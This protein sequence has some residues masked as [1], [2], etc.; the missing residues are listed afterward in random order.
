VDLERHPLLSEAAIEPSRV[1]FVGSM[2]WRANQ[3]AIDWF[4][5]E[6][7]PRLSKLI[8]YRLWV[9]GR[10]PPPWLLDRTR[11]P[12]QIEV[13]GEVEDVKPFFERSAAVVVPLRVGGGSR[14]KILEAFASAA[15][16]STIGAEGLNVTAGKE[17]FS[18]GS[19]DLAQSL[20]GLLQD[21]AAQ[22]L[23]LAA[24]RRVEAE[25]G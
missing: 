16:V 18:D 22:E 6:V 11:L 7:H 17:R 14:L 12:R 10:N 9:V 4:I 21:T 5:D 3:D 25:Y 2:D 19:A 24:R 15:V 13:T 1:L 20:A 8:D 23:I